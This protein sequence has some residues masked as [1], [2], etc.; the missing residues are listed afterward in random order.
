[1]IFEPSKITNHIA[2]LFGYGEIVITRLQIGHTRLTHVSSCSIKLPVHPAAV[3][4]LCLSN[5]SCPSH[6]QAR[7]SLPSVPALINDPINI[8]STLSYLK[9]MRLYTKI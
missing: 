4:N 9:A 8:D 3:V 7:S 2:I 1:M 6:N 5:T